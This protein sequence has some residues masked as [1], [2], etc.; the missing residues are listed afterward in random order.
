MPRPGYELIACEQQWQS[1]RPTWPT[2]VFNQL[3]LMAQRAAC[4]LDT[5]ERGVA[6]M[7]MRISST[8]QYVRRAASP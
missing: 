6:L 3:Q 7:A 2:A 8:P 4:R 5:G 1:K